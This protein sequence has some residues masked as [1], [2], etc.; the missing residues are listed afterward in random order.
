MERP[1]IILILSDQHRGDFLGSENRSI[2]TPNLDHL[3]A[4][5]A[6]FSKAYTTCP[7]C[8][9]ARR[10]ILSGQFPRSHG[11]VGYA[12]NQHWNHPPAMAEVLREAGYHTYFVGRSMHQHPPPRVAPPRPRHGVGRD[13]GDGV[14]DP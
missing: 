10:S 2:L 1:N 14:V 11:M 6:L 5:G 4:D 3:A 12:E 9:A 7:T 13:R 8:I